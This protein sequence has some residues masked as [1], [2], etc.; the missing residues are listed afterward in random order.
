VF[1]EKW[2]MLE[3]VRSILPSHVPWPSF[4]QFLAQSTAVRKVLTGPR[5]WGLTYWSNYTSTN[6]TTIFIFVVLTERFAV[7]ISSCTFRDCV[8]RTRE[9]YDQFWWFECVYLA[10]LALKLRLPFESYPDMT[11]VWMTRIVNTRSHPN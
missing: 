4:M 7:E 1:G 2:S 9:S 6:S 5:S 11:D 3:N 10:C 8:A